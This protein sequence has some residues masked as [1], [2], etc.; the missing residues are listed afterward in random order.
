MS[1]AC[2]PGSPRQGLDVEFE[3]VHVI[4]ELG[5]QFSNTCRIMLS[6]SLMRGLHQRTTAA[7]SSVI[8]LLQ[9]HQQLERPPPMQLVQAAAAVVELS[10]STE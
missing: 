10:H 3:S 6:P 5:G 7:P 2:T 8:I 1:P 4:H 9:Q